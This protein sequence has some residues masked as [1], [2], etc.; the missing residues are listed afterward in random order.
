MSTCLQYVKLQTIPQPR[1]F[2]RSSLELGSIRA[3]GDSSLVASVGLLEV[4]DVPDRLH[5]LCDEVSVRRKENQGAYTHIS[6]D[7]KVL[8]VESVLP[9]VDTDDREERKQRVLVRGRRDLQLLR[10]RV[11]TLLVSA[12][13]DSLSVAKRV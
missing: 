11:H 1:V 2:S 3:A 10:R 7:V 6:L 12:S 9:N 13:F 5:V 4:D 8:E